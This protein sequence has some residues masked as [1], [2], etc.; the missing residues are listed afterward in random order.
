MTPNSKV[1]HLLKNN[2][3]ENMEQNDN[4]K[5][6]FKKVLSGK[7]VRRYKVLEQIN[8]K[9]MRQPSIAKKSLLDMTRK[10]RNDKTTSTLEK[11]VN[12]FF[13]EDCNSRLCPGS[14]TDT[15]SVKC[16]LCVI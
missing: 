9:P 11:L 6:L 12:D 13:E 10:T 8:M 4:E 2:N 16:E 7:M 3:K 1:A 14:T 15:T 5:K